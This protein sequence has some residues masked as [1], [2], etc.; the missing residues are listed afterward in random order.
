VRYGR[1]KR[2]NL[3]PRL[4]ALVHPAE[5]ARRSATGNGAPIHQTFHPILIHP[6]HIA[7]RSD[8]ALTRALGVAQARLDGQER[9]EGIDKEEEESRPEGLR[10]PEMGRSGLE[11]D[12]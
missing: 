10:V 4:A 6:S 7:M 11:T 2:A 12:E 9:G 3:S 8:R 5:G 1:A